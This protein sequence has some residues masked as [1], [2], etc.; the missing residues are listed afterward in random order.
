MAKALKTYGM[1][2][3]V[4][5]ASVV[6]VQWAWAWVTSGW[7]FGKGYSKWHHGEYPSSAIPCCH[8]CHPL[9]SYAVMLQWDKPF[10]KC[11]TTHNRKSS[12][13]P[14]WRSSRPLSWT[15]IKMKIFRWTNWRNVRV[16]V[17]GCTSV[18]PLTMSAFNLQGTTLRE[19]RDF[20]W[21]RNW[22]KFT[23]ICWFKGKRESWQFGC[24]SMETS[25]DWQ[26]YQCGTLTSL[27]RPVFAQSITQ[28]NPPVIILTPLQ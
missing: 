26:R 7:T 6:R 18:N 27:M 12:C 4:I 24:T 2:F 25:G 10:I 19:K 3:I 8:P 9:P 11:C 22:S 17:E 28:S 14:K 5:P 23:C 1:A 21:I 16:E 20:P 15:E 13:H